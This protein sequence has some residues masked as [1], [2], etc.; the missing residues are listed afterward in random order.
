MAQIRKE[1]KRKGREEK[2][3]QG[4]EGGNFCSTGIYNG[5]GRLQN[6]QGQHS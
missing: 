2:K 5:M 6:F 1:K 3:G 4:R